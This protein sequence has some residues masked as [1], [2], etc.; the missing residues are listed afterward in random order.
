MI[1]KLS[2]HMHMRKPKC[3]KILLT[4]WIVH[5]QLLR[6]LLVPCGTICLDVSRETICCGFY[7]L[8]NLQSPEGLLDISILTTSPLTLCSWKLKRPTIKTWVSKKKVMLCERHPLPQSW[9]TT[10]WAKWLWDCAATCEIC[11]LTKG[12]C[13]QPITVKFKKW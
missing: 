10:S 1:H 9:N 3:S 13:K 5:H 11:N 12:H 6:R 4:Y 2:H 8:D 7:G